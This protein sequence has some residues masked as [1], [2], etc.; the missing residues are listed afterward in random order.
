MSEQPRGV[1]LGRSTGFGRAA[2]AVSA[3]A[4][5]MAYLEAAVVVYLRQA[6]HL[7]PSA[8]LPVNTANPLG[9]LTAIEAGREAATLVMFVAVGWITGRTSLER[10]AWVAVAFGM[11]DIWYYAWLWVFLGWPTS[12]GSWDLLFLLPVPWAGP[13]WAPIAVSAAL[14]LFGLAAARRERLAIHLRITRAQ[15]AAAGAG[16]VLVVLSFVLAAEPLVRGEVPTDYPWAVFAAGMGLAILA[17]ASA[18]RRPSDR[19]PDPG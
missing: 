3:Y 16:G 6:L 13:V 8:L 19:R 9:D 18:L 1:D 7:A 14:I 5:A 12:P 4:I 10:L 2:L 15:V 17:A 11:W